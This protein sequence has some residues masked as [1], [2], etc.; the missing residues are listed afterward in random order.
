MQSSALRDQILESYIQQIFARYD[1]D[2]NG[3][4]DPQEMTCFFNDLFR[5]LNIAMIVTEP[6]AI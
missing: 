4:L 6:Q 3:T 1:V 2:M 5:S